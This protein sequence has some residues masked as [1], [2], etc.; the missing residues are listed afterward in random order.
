MAAPSAENEQPWQFV[1]ITE[2]GI[3]NEI[4]TFH[5]YAQAVR[6]APVAILVCAD[7]AQEKVAG[8]SALDCSAATENIL[9]AACALG[10]GAVWLAIHGFEERVAGLRRLLS[11]PSHAVPFAL[12]ALGYPA[13]E[14]PPADRFDAK[15]VHHNRW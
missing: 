2:R 11:L 13:E 15:R 12:I 7:M 4:P 5:P 6:R 9:I 3:L 14:K 8:M 10:L 1:V